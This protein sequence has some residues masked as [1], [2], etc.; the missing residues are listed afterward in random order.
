MLP[1]LPDDAL[2]GALEFVCYVC[3]A[4]TA[5]VGYLLTMRF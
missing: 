1:L 3:T 2:S 4:L 5:V